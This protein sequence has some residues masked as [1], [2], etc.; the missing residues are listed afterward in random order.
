MPVP[1]K[2]KCPKRKGESDVPYQTMLCIACDTQ[3][4]AK[5]I[6]GAKHVP[7]HYFNNLERKGTRRLHEG[8][9]YSSS[10]SFSSQD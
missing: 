7:S 5:N 8:S 1:I 4:Q 3:H 9:N 2:Y 10:S 6:D